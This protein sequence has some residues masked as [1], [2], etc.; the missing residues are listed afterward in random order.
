MKKI[1]T[2]N[3][4]LKILSVV[5]AF[6]V[7]LAV[8][9][10]SNP[11]MSRTREIPL[12]VLNS[13][14]M[15]AAGLAYELDTKKST[16][17]VTYNTHT[18]DQANISTLDFRAYIN[19]EEYHPSIG[20]VPVYVEILNGKE[21]LVESCSAKPA[22]IRVKTEPLQK[23]DFD[24]VINEI[25]VQQSG[26]EVQGISLSP[27]MVTVKGP[28][29]VIGR[30]NAVGV[31]INKEG[32][33][34]DTS[35]TAVPLFYDS[36]GNQLSMDDR[37]TIN[38]SEIAYTIHVVKEKQ[39]ALEFEVGGQA[40]EGY[41]YV[42][43]ETNANA[44]SVI[45]QEEIVDAVQAIKIPGSVLNLDGATEDR[46]I[47]VDVE[48][49][50][51]DKE[52]M[53]IPWNSQVVVRLKVEPL[54]RRTIIIPANR[55]IEEGTKD[56]YYYEYSQDSVEVVAEGLSAV[57]D[58]LELTDII[59]EL[60]VSSLE[61]GTYNAELTFEGLPDEVSVISHSAIQVM[62]SSK[63]GEPDADTQP[64]SSQENE[65]LTDSGS[66]TS[67]GTASSLGET[68]EPGIHYPENLE[69]SRSWA[70]NLAETSTED[71]SVQAAN[72]NLAET[73]ISMENDL[74][75]TPP[76]EVTETT[77]IEDTEGGGQ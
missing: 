52:K 64:E 43:M 47:T 39:I 28:E 13:A 12:E 7:W 66:E 27:K 44:V 33:H 59:A 16:I 2:H 38:V 72:S 71:E 41:Q 48:E 31:E 18:Q 24:L 40:A 1:L 35:G 74:L 42:G 53:S 70:D 46:V 19:L 4:G 22:V 34:E 10:V 54:S 37:V 57:L 67:T 49:Y 58:G 5:I 14:K 75:Q 63:E 8:V 6:F 3:L 15:E 60:D 61:V 36:N 68:R 21:Y 69:T 29:S 20:N 9:S 25:G 62:V 51:P 17:T 77:H 32:V 26:Y 55:I 11:V 76:T 65:S 73:S 56:E 30:I 23:K 50:L 45:G